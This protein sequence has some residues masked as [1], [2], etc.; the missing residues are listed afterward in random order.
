MHQLN[1]EFLSQF[2]NCGLAFIVQ[3]ATAEIN[4]DWVLS[5]EPVN[6]LP[7]TYFVALPQKLTYL[8]CACSVKK[9]FSLS[10]A[11]VRDTLFVISCWPLHLTIM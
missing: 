5:T 2:R 8:K 3:G 9:V 7:Y 4:S 6:T 1:C 11:S 10:N